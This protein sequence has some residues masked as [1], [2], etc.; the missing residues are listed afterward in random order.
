MPSATAALAT[1]APMAPNPM[2]PSVLPRSSGPTKAFLPFST[3]LAIVSRPL[4]VC[5][6]FTAST[7]LRLPATSAPT[8]SSATA[9]A[10]APGVLNTTMPLF[11][12][13]STGMLFVPAPARAMASRLSGSGASCI[14]ALRTRMPCGAAASLSISNWLAGSLARPTGEMAFNVLIVYIY[15][16]SLFPLFCAVGAGHARPSALRSD[17]LTG[18]CHSA[19]GR[20]HPTPA[21]QQLNAPCGTSP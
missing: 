11:V 6:Q 10:L 3:S 16:Y 1:R 14:S 9:L 2:T 12:Q 20:T 18:G 5:A 17:P 13:S 15:R 8:T 7:R 21:V 19:A 4:R